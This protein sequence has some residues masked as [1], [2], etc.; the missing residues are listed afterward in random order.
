MGKD[1][2][3]CIALY[4]E[5]A[6]VGIYVPNLS[7]KGAFPGRVRECA[8]VSAAHEAVVSVMEARCVKVRDGP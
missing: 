4:L 1:G 3:K 7:K 6:G 5:S 2:R 8:T